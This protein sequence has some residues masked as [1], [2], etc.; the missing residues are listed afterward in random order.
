MA[1]FLSNAALSLPRPSAVVSPRTPSSSLTTTGSP[2]RCGMDTG[3]ISASKRPF[4]D[5]SA[6]RWCDAAE[7][8]SMSS[9]L[10][11]IEAA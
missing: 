8:A 9:R 10:R 1:P 11:P 6:A 3:A 4:F 7:N 2:L 5:A